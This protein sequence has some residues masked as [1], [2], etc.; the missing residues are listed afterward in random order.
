M[1]VIQSEVLKN[2]GFPC[3]KVFG[4]VG[5]LV[6]LASAQTVTADFGNRSYSSKRVF[7]NSLGINLASL[8]NTNSISQ[9]Q[10]A[11][12]TQTRKMANIAQIYATTTANWS[13]ID[14]YMK[15]IAPSGMHPLI[16]MSGCALMAAAESQSVWQW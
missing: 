12:I 1:V 2:A 8:Q 13:S 14:W 3:F 11:G 15:M 4:F 7:A 5:V 16:V 6:S 9:N 10:Q